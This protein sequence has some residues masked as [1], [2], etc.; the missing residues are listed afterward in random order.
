MKKIGF[1]LAASLIVLTYPVLVAFAQTDSQRGYTGSYAPPG[2]QPAPYSTGALPEVD[3]GSPGLDVPGPDG[4]TK[5]VKPVPCSSAAMETDGSTTCV[6]IE[7]NAGRK[8]R[9]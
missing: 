6:G 9:Q 4:S 3:D 2:T 1:R 8:S 5:E 7:G